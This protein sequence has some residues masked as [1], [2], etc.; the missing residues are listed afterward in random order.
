M[1]EKTLYALFKVVLSALLS[2]WVFSACEKETISEHPTGPRFSLMLEEESGPATKSLLQSADIETKITSVT[3]A[4]YQAGALVDAEHY[5][6]RFDQ[7]SFPLE[8]GVYTV[9]ALVNMGDMREVLPENESELSSL[10]YSI[11]GYQEPGTGIEYRGIPMAGQL[12]CTVG[13]TDNCAIPVKRLLAKVTAVLSC[14]WTGTIS[15]VKVFNL[16]RTLKPFGTSVAVSSADILPVQEF[17]SG[18]GTTS[19]TYVFYV[20]ENL[21]GSISGIATPFEK[22]PE[23]HS[24]VDAKKGLMTYLETLVSGTSGVEGTIIYRSFLGDN[25]TTSFD[26][27]RNWRYTWTLRF[28]P[29]GRLNNDWKHENRLSWSEYR[30]Y[31]TPAT[32]TL[33]E[34]EGGL[35]DILRAEDLYKNG[36]LFA[37]GGGSI[38]YGSHFNWSYASLTNPSIVNDHGAITGQLLGEKYYVSAVGSGTRRITA[39]GPDGSADVNLYCDVTSLGYKRQ[40]LLMADPGPRAVVGET[41]R[42]KALVYTTQNGVTTGGTDVTASYDCHIFRA[43]YEGHNAVHV[44][45]QGLV[46][47]TGPDEERFSA[48]Y[49]YYADGK[50]IYANGLYVTFEETRTGNLSIIG[51]SRPGTVGSSIQLQ[52]TFTQYS[53]GS[54]I[55]TTD[56]TSQA[57]WNIQD[58]DGVSVSAGIVVGTL[59][60]ASVVQATYTAPNG[61]KYQAQSIVLFNSH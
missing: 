41:V 2:A 19:G 25:A 27:N 44:P 35:I 30:Y 15:S 11:P 49:D 45:S 23:G 43:G 17:Q 61:K 33:Y 50:T 47:A 6:S 40:L 31:I 13:L 56:V 21:Q 51:V 10:V 26:I 12:S 52:A 29:D 53:N 58:G 28:L 24:Q 57:V 54:P 42:L 34:G 8:D 59:P 7:M 32:M 16:N 60:G 20:P 22:S 36:S 55:G 18:G 5:A 4:L 1:T 14:E 38:S 3:L 37:N 48:S 46:T 9:Y 39:T